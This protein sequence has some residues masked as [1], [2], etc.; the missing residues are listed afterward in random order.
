MRVADV[1]LFPFLEELVRNIFHFVRGFNV[2]GGN[3]I[4]DIGTVF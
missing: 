3:T 2:R 4:T 1:L